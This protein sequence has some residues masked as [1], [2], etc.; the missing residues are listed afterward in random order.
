MSDQEQLKPKKYQTLTSSGGFKI[1]MLIIL[2]LLL[3]I[4]IN[5]IRSLVNERSHR[6]S[7]AESSIMEAW[8]SQFM[9][10]GPVIRIPLF[11]RE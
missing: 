11:E 6:A 5:M 1:A 8:G 3:L 10:Y 9:L 7:D 4:P 2:V